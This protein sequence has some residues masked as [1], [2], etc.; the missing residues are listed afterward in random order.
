MQFKA[1]WFAGVIFKRYIVRRLLLDAAEASAVGSLIDAAVQSSVGEDRQRPRSKQALAKWL[2]ARRDVV[3]PENAC[4]HAGIMLEEELGGWVTVP[5]G[6]KIVVGKRRRKRL[7]AASLPVPATGAAEAAIAG[8]ADTIGHV[9][10]DDKETPYF[11]A[12]QRRQELRT[13]RLNTQRR[14]ADHKCSN[15]LDGENLDDYADSAS[16]FASVISRSRVFKDIASLAAVHA[17]LPCHQQVNEWELLFCNHTHGS[18]LATFSRLC[19]HKGPNLIL[20]EDT[21]GAIF[22]GYA[23]AAW[24]AAAGSDGNFFGTG[25]SFLWRLVDGSGS[26]IAGLPPREGSVVSAEQYRWTR[27]TQ[28]QFMRIAEDSLA[29]GGR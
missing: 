6:Q 17:L 20:I 10:N 4:E 1:D 29:M 13:A 28:G 9:S 21:S 25:Q 8:G 12:A 14:Q 5:A 24:R 2:L 19:S 26:Q 16:I 7:S 11:N 18:S 23:S 3:P 27:V 22:G 15:G